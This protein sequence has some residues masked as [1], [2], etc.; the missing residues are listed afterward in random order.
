MFNRDEQLNILYD[1]VYYISQKQPKIALATATSVNYFAN[2]NEASTYS[3]AVCPDAS[4]ISGSTLLKLNL[5][6]LRDATVKK[7]DELKNVEES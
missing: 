2:L 6:Q 3:L 5:E 4:R 1:E 7:Y